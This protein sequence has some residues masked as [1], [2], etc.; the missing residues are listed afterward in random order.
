MKRIISLALSLALLLCL[1]PTPAL[2]ADGALSSAAV[3]V[4]HPV[5]GEYPSPL[6]YPAEPD[7]YE[8]KDFGYYPVNANGGT[9]TSLGW[10]TPFELNTVYRIYVTLRSLNGWTITE[11]TKLTINGREAKL[12][13]LSTSTR[14]VY[15]VDVKA[16]KTVFEDVQ[17]DDWFAEAVQYCFEFN[18]MV[19]TSDGS[20]FSPNIPFTRGMFVTVL[21][22]IDS[23]DTSDYTGSS[24]TDVKAGKWYAPAVEW[25]FQNGYASGVGNSKFAPDTGVT[26]EMLAVF[27]YKYTA[28]KY[29][30]QSLVGGAELSS[31]ADSSKISS[32]ARDAMAWAV[33]AGL[34]GGVK[35]GGKT[36]LLPSRISSRAVVAQIVMNYMC[37][38]VP[39]S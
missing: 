29:G 9:G 14:A 36:Y 23:A 8:V 16:G 25:A 10:N 7:R 30:Q 38:V 4:S 31:Y 3:Q 32:W 19:G 5:A 11:D 21:S 6:S 1:L 2:A 18:L 26:R 37:K 35:Q 17:A 34:I 39:Q 22:K 15:Y 28:K 27:L 33:K 12:Q 20:V 24:F 13:N